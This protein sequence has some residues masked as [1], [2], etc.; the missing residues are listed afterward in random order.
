MLEA[1][2]QRMADEFWE[3]ARNISCTFPRDIEAAVAWSLPLFIVRFPNLWV[4]DVESYLRQ[5][6]SLPLSRA[7]DRPLHGCVIAVRGKG[8]IAVNGTDNPCDVRFT[9]AH[10]IA[11]FL[12]DYHEPRLRALRRFGSHI[13]AVLDGMRPPTEAERIDGILAS[14]PIQLFTHFMHRDDAGTAGA[15]VLEAESQADL[16]AFELIA[17]DA[18]VWRLAPRGFA[19]RTY[20]ARIASLQRLLVRRF[21]L[22]GEVAHKYAA[23][24]CHSRFGNKSVRE[25]L[26]IT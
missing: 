23:G 7:A 3:T 19:N 13:E 22:P 24:L 12:V 17:P 14:T 6:Q 4:H 18:E 20:N 11:H 9:I 15:A 8:F 1:R 21:G 26:G 2:L 10:E 5:K 25:W 16:L